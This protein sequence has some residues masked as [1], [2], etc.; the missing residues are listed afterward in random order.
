MLTRSAA[1]IPTLLILFLLTVLI[2]ICTCSSATPIPEVP[3]MG[4]DE[5]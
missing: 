3:I 4:P 1:E 5:R 2:A